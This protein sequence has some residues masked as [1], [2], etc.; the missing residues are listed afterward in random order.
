M[1]EFFR[2]WKRKVGVLT[3]VMA[4]LLMGSWMRSRIGW[5]ALEFFR[6]SFA[7]QSDNGH[8]LLA[9]IVINP[10]GRELKWSSMP[11]HYWMGPTP[12]NPWQPIPFAQNKIDW[13]FRWNGFESGDVLTTPV[14]GPSQTWMQFWQV[15]YWSIVLPLTLISAFLLLSKPRKSI[16]TKTAQPVANEGEGVAS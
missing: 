1:G 3:L 12:N 4:C 5:D 8:L 2:G 13:S 14:T 16:Q 6:G 11:G 9:R 10:S 7:I 15:P